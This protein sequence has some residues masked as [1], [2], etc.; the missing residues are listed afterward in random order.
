MKTLE[1]LYNIQKQ[2]KPYYDLLQI[3]NERNNY[4]AAISGMITFGVLIQNML[5]YDKWKDFDNDYLVML[6]FKKIY[7]DPSN[8]HKLMFFLENI[9]MIIS[10]YLM[11]IEEEE[12]F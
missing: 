8:D 10:G 1:D 7:T 2:I 4:I 3:L 6:A 5:S 11:S 9:D 12:N